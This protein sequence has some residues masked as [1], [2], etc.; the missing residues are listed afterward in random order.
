MIEARTSGCL[1]EVKTAGENFTVS[2]R[3]RREQVC[4]VVIVSVNCDYDIMT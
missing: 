1:A 3:S 4:T 2:L